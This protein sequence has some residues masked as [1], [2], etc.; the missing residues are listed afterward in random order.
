MDKQQ[1][2]EVVEELMRVR[3]VLIQGGRNGEAARLW[4]V[5]S[6]LLRELAKSDGQSKLQ[7]T[8]LLRHV[9]LA[10]QAIELVKRG[11]D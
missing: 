6:K 2:L 5:I 3:D 11:F 10:V 8:E 1:S 7:P 9:G 4:W